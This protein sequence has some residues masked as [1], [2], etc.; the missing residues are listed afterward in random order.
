MYKTLSQ[1]NTASAIYIWLIW[2]CEILKLSIDIG[3]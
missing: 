3:S 1:A 2:F